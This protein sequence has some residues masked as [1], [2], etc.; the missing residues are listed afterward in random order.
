MSVEEAIRKLEDAG[1]AISERAKALGDTQ[2]TL[3]PVETAYNDFIEA[4]TL[5][6]YDSGEKLPS[7]SIRLALAHRAM[8]PELLSRYRTLTAKR[9]RLKKEISDL[10]A[11]AEAQRSVLSAE[12]TIVEGGG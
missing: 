6:L 7:E 12:K 4:H 3:E 1:F 10:R 5:G 8:E 2:R 11:A 9:E